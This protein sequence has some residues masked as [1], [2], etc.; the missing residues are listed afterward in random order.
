MLL[1]LFSCV[2]DISVLTS[3]RV[4]NSFPSLR[5]MSLTILDLSCATWLLRSRYGFKVP[6]VL[7]LGSTG[8]SSWLISRASANS[9]GGALIGQDP[10]D[11][12]AG[13]EPC[14]QI[15]LGCPFVSIIAKRNMVRELAAFSVSFPF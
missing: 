12:I 4:L 14:V 8:G 1:S 10:F 3:R 2:L 9:C 5:E 6:S 15:A 11:W 7:Q 13:V